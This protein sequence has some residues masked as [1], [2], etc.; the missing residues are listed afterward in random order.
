MENHKECSR[1]KYYYR[2]YL[3]VEE[4]EVKNYQGKYPDD[5]ILFPVE[6]NLEK[7]YRE[8]K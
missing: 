6:E 4:H 7:I 1:Y 5:T 3:K 8:K 2:R